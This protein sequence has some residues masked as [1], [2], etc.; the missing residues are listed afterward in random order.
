MGVDNVRSKTIYE[1]TDL[2]RR[3]HI[4]KDTMRPFRFEVEVVQVSPLQRGDQYAAFLTAQF[5]SETLSMKRTA[6]GQK[7]NFQRLLQ[8]NLPNPLF[9][10]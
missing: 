1:S 4:M 9:I 8:R 6:F 7:E 2:C 10:T 3:Q 5:G